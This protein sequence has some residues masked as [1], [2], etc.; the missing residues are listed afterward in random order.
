MA[1]PVA[2]GVKLQRPLLDAV[3]E[4]VARGVKKDEA[5]CRFRHT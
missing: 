5:R 2:R 3:L 4:L 1:K